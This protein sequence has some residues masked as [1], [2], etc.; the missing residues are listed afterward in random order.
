MHILFFA[1]IHSHFTSVRPVAVLCGVI[2][3]IHTLYACVYVNVRMHKHIRL[4]WVNLQLMGKPVY[5]QLWQ[6]QQQQRA[7]SNDSYYIIRTQHTRTYAFA[8]KSAGEEAIAR[9]RVVITQ[10]VCIDSTAAAA[11]TAFFILPFLLPLKPYHTH[12]FQSNAATAPHAITHV[13]VFSLSFTISVWV[14]VLMYITTYI[15]LVQRM[16]KISMLHNLF[17]MRWCDDK[18]CCYCCVVCI[19]FSQKCVCECCA[20]KQH[21]RSRSRTMTLGWKMWAWKKSGEKTN[22]VNGKMENACFVHVN[23]TN[24]WYV[25]MLA[26]TVCISST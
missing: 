1:V 24:T 2:H 8:A 22:E 6:Q 19:W 26:T 25:R 17:W 9:A 10:C 4:N 18:L 15:P 20:H 7:H 3:T 11:A 13:F 12:C 16:R 21:T 5:V 14:R 23:G